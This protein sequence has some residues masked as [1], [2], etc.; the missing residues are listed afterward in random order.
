MN[1]KLTI[2][3]PT[4]NG[5]ETISSTL[6]SILSQLEDNVEVVVCDNAS[7]DETKQIVLKYTSQ[8]SCIKYFQN[9][10]NV[11]GCK[12]ISLVFE[13]ASGDFVWLLGDD[14]RI[15][16][17]GIKKVIDVVLRNP[18]LAFIFVNLSI[19]NRDFSICHNRR[20]LP[21][22]NDLI[23]IDANEY[24]NL[25]RQ[26][27]AFTPTQVI[28][29]KLWLEID[30]HLFDNTGWK[31]L[32]YLFLLLP[33]RSAYVIGE[34]Y[35][36]FADGSLRHHKDGAFYYQMLDLIKLFQYL[37]TCGYNDNLCEKMIKSILRNLPL[38]IFFSKEYGL[39]VNKKLL[40]N[41]ISTLGRY[42]Y[43]WFFCIPILMMPKKILCIVHNT[44]RYLKKGSV[45]ATKNLG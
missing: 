23:Y 26:N 44:Y 32:Y 42:F 25:V 30:S 37:P 5:A 45:T 29:R 19:W 35:A 21:L 11:G 9:D 22:E 33:G 31:T 27:A 18:E 40:N 34:P 4:Y 39:K 43:F 6:D 8:Y 20:F 36:L 38:T 28:N 17:G 13:R 1:V 24:F 3:I 15:K 16:D 7:T 10:T 12:N 41:S 14:D 2:G